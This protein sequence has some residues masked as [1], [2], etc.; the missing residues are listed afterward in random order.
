[1]QALDFRIL[2]DAS[3]NPYMVLDR[4][5]RYVA[6]NT[7]YLKVTA[8]R[9]EDLVG[10]HLFDVFPHD[11]GDP[12][13]Q[14]ARRLRESLRRV[15]ASRAPD[16]IAY[17]PYRVPAARD[18][19]VVVEERLWSAT[20]T[21]ILDEAGDVQ[22]ILQHTVDVTE[23]RR[24]G[25]DDVRPPDQIQAGVLQR[26]ERLQQANYSLDAERLYLRGLFEQAPGF[27]CILRGPD[28]VFELVNGAYQQL[29][30]HREMLGKTV[31]EA[32]PE[33]EGQGY[34][35][36]LD[37][38]FRTGEPFLGSEMKMRL[39][40]HA[41][42]E[43]EEVCLNF[44]YQPIVDASG[45]VTGIFVQGQDITAQKRLEADREALMQRQQF[46]TESIPQQVWTADASGALVNVN[47]RVL[48]YFS[49]GAEH[50]LGWNWLRFVHPDD[51]P[52]SQTR[53]AH[54]IA[55]GDEYEIEF[56]LRRS[57]GDYR[58][59]LGRAVAL[60]EPDGRISMWFGTNT[61]IDDRK[62]AQDK[63]QE[64]SSF[65]QHLIGIVSHDLRN[66]INAIG[67][68]AALLR[69]RGHLD[70]LQG[71]A[72]ARIVSSTDRARRLIRDFLDF[73]QART[74]GRIPVSPRPANIQE[75]A[76]QVFD[77]VLLT[78]GDQ[79]ATYDHEG[80][81]DGTWDA[82]RLAQVI[83][84]LLGN[85]F[86]HGAPGGT[87]RLRTRGTSDDVVIEVQNEGQ[88][89][90]AAD[91]ARLFRPFE[92]GQGTVPSS[93]RSVGLGLYI[94]EQIVAAHGGTI[95]VRSTAQAGTVFTV[96]LPRRVEAQ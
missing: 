14:N 30:G 18:G 89:I 73:T 63:L 6:A 38:V 62:R 37:R 64:Q 1:M 13:N 52:S 17:I 26:A 71:K 55:T 21:P 94:S 70:D 36:T 29:T 25:R 41:A 53:W 57:D 56:R 32:L 23:L 11:P 40:R 72:V 82:D 76:R 2:F 28:H 50:I 15:V 49:V 90:P 85:A 39:Q 58:W 87:V 77:E 84:N 88:P 93:A 12:D 16:V 42:G 27:V 95:S 43:P 65:E 69:Q 19:G 91:L 10:R 68:A 79:P 4:E 7:A 44:V 80:E 20:H 83:G 3:P 8:S 66:P 75:I 86:Q 96:R 92:R 45:S 78:H 5:F 74:S 31:R 61:D 47:Q 24:F 22:F 51:L 46:L 48:D 9:L 59:H 60:R 35:E 34:F 81:T 67:I 54:S 33:I